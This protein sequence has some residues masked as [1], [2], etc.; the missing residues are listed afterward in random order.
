[1]AFNETGLSEKEIDKAVEEWKKE[2]DKVI[3]R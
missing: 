2:R 1:M 3:P